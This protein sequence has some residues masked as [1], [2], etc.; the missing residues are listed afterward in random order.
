ME[1]SRH[2]ERGNII[3]CWKTVDTEWGW[4]REAAAA[5][6]HFVWIKIPK[7]SHTC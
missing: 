5:G 2:C 1:L 4:G 7:R 6:T 3:K